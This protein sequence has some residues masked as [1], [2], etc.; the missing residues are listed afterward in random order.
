MALVPLRLSRVLGSVNAVDETV[1]LLAFQGSPLGLDPEQVPGILK[2]TSSGVGSLYPDDDKCA[3]SAY[4]NTLALLDADTA[5]TTRWHDENGT[6]T[7]RR[8]GDAT[9]TMTKTMAR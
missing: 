2:L 7:R 4:S 8:E 5:T 1:G 3:Q 6:V 9:R